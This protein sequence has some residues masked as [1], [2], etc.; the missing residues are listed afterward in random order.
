MLSKRTGRVTVT[1][2][3]GE[4]VLTEQ[5]CGYKYWGI[6]ESDGGTPHTE[7]QENR[8]EGR[9]MHPRRKEAAGSP[10]HLSE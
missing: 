4:D 9:R 7:G 8:A 1:S 5:K 6:I 2:A 10:N 3:F